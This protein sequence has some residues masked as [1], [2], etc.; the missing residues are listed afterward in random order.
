MKRVM[1][2]LSMPSVGSWNGKWT[3]AG[4]RYFIVKNMPDK[5]VGKL[6]DGKTDRSWHHTWGDGWAAC[7]TASIIEKGVRIG[8]SDGFCGYEW[9]VGNIMT[10]GST[11][12]PGQV[13]A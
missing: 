13:P 2:R 7:V 12:K 5:F 10:Y 3:G 4:R 8:K 1:F 11:T 6:L 9:M